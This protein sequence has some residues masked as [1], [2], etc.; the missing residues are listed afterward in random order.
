MD[1]P[2][3]LDMASGGGDPGRVLQKTAWGRDDPP[4][5]DLGHLPFKA[6]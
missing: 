4:G 6:G 2:V 1:A 3:Q 5:R